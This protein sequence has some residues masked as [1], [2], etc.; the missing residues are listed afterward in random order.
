MNDVDGIARATVTLNGGSSVTPTA[1]QKPV[2]SG[3]P[4]VTT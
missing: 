4:T 2:V 1:A 3:T